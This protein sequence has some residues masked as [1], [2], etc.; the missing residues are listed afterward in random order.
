M[1]DDGSGQA[2]GAFKKEAKETEKFTQTYRDRIPSM[3]INMSNEYREMIFNPYEVR[4]DQWNTF[5][6][7]TDT[8]KTQRHLLLENPWQIGGDAMRSMNWYRF[9]Y[10]NSVN[11]L[12]NIEKKGSKGEVV[13]SVA[14]ITPSL[15]NPKFGVIST[16][17]AYVI[18]YA[19][20]VMSLSL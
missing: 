5:I 9:K 10:N 2:N 7:Q 14:S 1:N 13:H 6:Q 3:N 11:N 19:A 15:F 8:H 16:A 18:V 12:V 4:Y 17:P 20:L